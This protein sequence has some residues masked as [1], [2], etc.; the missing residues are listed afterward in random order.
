[1]LKTD[2]QT[3]LPANYFTRHPKMDPKSQKICC[4]QQLDEG[5]DRQEKERLRD[6]ETNVPRAALS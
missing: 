6:L 4:T 5:S 3:N 2:H 1:M